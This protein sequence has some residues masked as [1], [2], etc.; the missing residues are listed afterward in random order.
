MHGK[1]FLHKNVFQTLND[2]TNVT[3]FQLTPFQIRNCPYKTGGRTS[4]AGSYFIGAQILDEKE[5]KTLKRPK[6]SGRE[7][8]LCCI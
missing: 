6:E 1:V 5:V 8:R 4:V 7:L 3:I 2:V